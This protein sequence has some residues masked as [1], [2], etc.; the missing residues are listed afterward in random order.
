MKNSEKLFMKI[1]HLFGEKSTCDRANVGCVIVKDGRIISTG[2]NGS[3]S[4][5]PH[6]DE[7]GHLMIEGHCLRTIHAEQNAL[8]F[9]ARKGISVEGADAYVTHYPCVHCLKLLIQAGI[10]N[11][12]YSDGY[13]MNENPFNNLV[14]AKKVEL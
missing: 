6:C 3:L 2:F 8:M 1:A 13:R 11:I 4:K 9:C 7:V 14:N 10:K 12:Y 5:Q